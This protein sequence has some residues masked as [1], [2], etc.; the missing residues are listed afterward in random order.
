MSEQQFRVKIFSDSQGLVQQ[1]SSGI[2]SDPLTRNL[3]QVNTGEQDKRSDVVLVDYN[4]IAQEPAQALNKLLGSQLSSVAILLVSPHQ[5]TNL[6]FSIYGRF[7]YC[8][9]IPTL[10][11]DLTEAL[12]TVSLELEQQKATLAQLDSANEMAMIALASNS[13]YGHALQFIE[14]TYE[15][16]DVD[17]L[18]SKLFSLLHGLNLDATVMFVI[19]GVRHYFASNGKP[20]CPKHLG[21]FATMH[22]Q[23]RI[24]DIDQQCLINFPKA[25][26]LLHNMPLSQPELYGRLKDL[27][28]AILGSVEAKVHL[29]ETDQVIG[30]Q[31]STSVAG[32][33]Q[34]KLD[35]AILTNTYGDAFVTKLANMRQAVDR[36]ISLFEN[37]DTSD[38]SYSIKHG[39]LS[40]LQDLL[41]QS[42]QA[43]LVSQDSLV[44]SAYQVDTMMAALQQISLQYNKDQEEKQTL[45]IH[46]EDDGIELF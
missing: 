22:A 25:S 4:C 8:I 20:P 36:L 31:A 21:I 35:I 5:L 2:D 27:M 19:N 26:L 46:S 9:K 43:I 41:E 28:P 3:F 38:C 17:S 16:H 13:E 18:A 12:A 37:A 23:G 30:A 44:S 33:E 42:N 29:L 39:E 14:K 7:R 40:Q 45:T 32:L 10:A 6:P 1:I 11:Q 24:I 15:L 34:L